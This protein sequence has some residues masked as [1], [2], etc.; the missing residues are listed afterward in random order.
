M[1][2]L[3]KSETVRLRSRLLLQRLI[4]FANYELTDCEH[5]ESKISVR[6]I[7]IETRQP[8]LIVKTEIRFL[9]ALV[10]PQKANDAKTKQHLKQDLRSLKDFLGILEDNRDRTQG[11][12]IW[13]FPLKLW[14]RRADPNLTAFDATFV[15]YE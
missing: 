7:D 1:P 3:N 15:A 5:L 12:G 2:Q 14:H 8:K 9:A 4:D 13:H 6:W 11:T 10:S